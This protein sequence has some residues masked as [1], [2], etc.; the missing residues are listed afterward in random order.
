METDK[1]IIERLEKDLAELKARLPKEKKVKK[2]K[3]L[4]IGKWYKDGKFIIYIESINGDKYGRY[5]FNL[6]GE[7]HHVNDDLAIKDTLK[8]ASPSVVFEALKKEAIKRGYKKGVT[9]V[10]VA[11][12]A[13]HVV[14]SGS[15]KYR[16][17]FDDLV[18]SDGVI[19]SNG[20]WAAIIENKLELNG[21]EVDSGNLFIKIGCREFLT[22]DFR[23]AI[24]MLEKGGIT[25]I[26]HPDL[27][28]IKVSDL[29]NLIN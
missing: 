16:N 3:E 27:G 4:E 29:K 13:R 28:D 5:G 9:F 1:K 14:F 6:Y 19:F 8:P 20:V 22:E 7:W 2:K 26:D 24:V 15:L 12:D 17:G 25:S 23:R 18:P 21:K 10:S 11:N